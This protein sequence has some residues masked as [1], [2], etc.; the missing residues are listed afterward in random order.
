MSKTAVV[1]ITDGH[2]GHDQGLAHPDTELKDDLP[3]K[4]EP[5]HRQ[6]NLNPTQLQL[7]DIVT[8]AR[9]WL[10]KNCRGWNKIL[11]N[12]GEIIQG[13]KYP[14]N[15][16]TQDLYE[17]VKMGFDT[18]APWM[19]IVDKVYLHQATTW[20]EFGNGSASKLI[21]DMLRMKYKKPV[22]H[23]HKFRFDIDGF[24][25]QTTHHGPAT[26]KRKRLED[27]AARWAAHDKIMVG[28]IENEP[29]PDLV[30]TAH[31]HKPSWGT[32][33]VL[34]NGGY[35][36]CDWIITPPMCGA[37]AF[38]RKISG[39]DAYYV[40][41]QILQIVDGSLVHVEPFYTRIIDYEREV[42]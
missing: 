24:L 32:A 10:G 23:A 39:Q 12:H 2:S 37:G 1:I 5:T 38:S 9:T 42:I 27:S 7:Y 11:I 22:R 4:G 6:I 3:M 8:T 21:G 28:K 40:G 20:H 41:M 33:H 18:F 25:L 29:I 17:Q 30:V 14:D 15:L 19:D 13:N 36:T 26:S 16:M 31:T 35:E 34:A